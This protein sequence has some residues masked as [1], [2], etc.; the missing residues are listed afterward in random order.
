MLLK[1]GL[2]SDE[3]IEKA[4]YTIKLGKLCQLEVSREVLEDMDVF[5]GIYHSHPDY[6]KNPITA[7][8]K[9]PFTIKNNSNAIDVNLTIPEMNLNMKGFLVNLKKENSVYIN[10]SIESTDKNSEWVLLL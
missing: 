7:N 1:I 8:D 10:F 4:P 3:S 9:P 6:V 2:L 5:I